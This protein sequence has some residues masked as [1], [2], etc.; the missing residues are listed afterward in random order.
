MSGYEAITRAELVGRLQ[1]FYEGVPFWTTTEAQD[2]LNEGLRFWNALTGRWKTRVVI[3]TSPV[4]TTTYALP[5]TLTYRARVTFNGQ[6]MSPSS[7]EDLL[8]GRP[9][10]YLETTASGGDVPT[11]PTLW[12]PRSLRT[13]DIWPMDAVG[14]NSLTLDGVEDTPTLESDTD[15]VDLAEADISNLLGYCLHAVSLKKGGPWFAATM[16]YFLQ[17]LEAAG[18]ENDLI[19]T[20]Q[21]YRRVMGLDNRWKASASAQSSVQAIAAAIAQQISGAGAPR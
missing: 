4:L 10:W 12:A 17:F 20:S 21:L 7:R 5:T 6:P 19:L 14:H 9:R 13:I 11:V 1:E 8:S 16:S 18:E 3:E 15:Y 2:A